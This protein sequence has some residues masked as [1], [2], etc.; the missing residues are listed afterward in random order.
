MRSTPG[1][2]SRVTWVISVILHGRCI[3]TPVLE[4]EK[5]RPR[6]GQY[7]ARIGGSGSELGFPS[8][9][10]TAEPR[11]AGYLVNPGLSVPFSERERGRFNI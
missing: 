7:G 9:S 10:S 2:M 6:E 5:A 8:C 4:M 1:R 3:I 11:W